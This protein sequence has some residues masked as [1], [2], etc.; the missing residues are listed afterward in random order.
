[1]DHPGVRAV[2]HIRLAKGV[3]D[4]TKAEWREWELKLDHE[5]TARLET[6]HPDL[7][8]L[9]RHQVPVRVDAER[10]LERFRRNAGTDNRRLPDVTERIPSIPP[11][12]DRN[13]ARYRSILHQFPRVYGVGPAGLPPQASVQHQAQMKQ[14]KAYLQLFDQLLAD[15]FAQAANAAGLLAADDPT[16]PTYAAGSVESKDQELGDLAIDE[17]RV[18]DYQSAVDAAA[19]AASESPEG[20]ALR[21]RQL[22]HLLARVGETY[23]DPLV[24]TDT[25]DWDGLEERRALLDGIAQVTASRGQAGNSLQ[26]FG[27]DNRGGLEHRIA[28]KLGLRPENGERFLLVEHLLLR[29]LPEDKEQSEPLLAEVASADP[30][31]LQLSF[32]FPADAGRFADTQA[33]SSTAR[34]RQG[35]RCYVEHLI[36]EET[37]AHLT[38]Y[39]HWLDA[40]AYSAFEQDLG[41]WHERRRANLLR[42]FN[43]QEGAPD[44]E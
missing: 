33:S 5:E 34:C 42:R 26:P 12:R 17:V 1:M 19:Q 31:S 32:V 18:D 15:Q 11:G 4:L 41:Q 27:I 36:R 6:K 23:V 2:R 16:T 29:A 9:Y 14:L 28:L 38:I 44:H 43:I 40:D 8:R 20:I 37:P 30:Y 10:V 24:A 21:R 25:S 22:D 35:F 13:I 3:S 7:I 39:I